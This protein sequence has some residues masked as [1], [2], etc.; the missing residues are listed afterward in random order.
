MLGRKPTIGLAMIVKDEAT[1]IGRCLRSVYGH[2]DEVL[3]VDTGSTDGTQAIAEAHGARVIPFAWV[4]DF[5]AARNFALENATTDWVLVLDADEE[6]E[7]APGTLQKV[8]EGLAI[9]QLTGFVPLVWVK[10]YNHAGSVVTRD[11]WEAMP[12]P[13]FFSREGVRYRGAAHE[14]PELPPG[15]PYK[16]LAYTAYNI[17][18]HHHGYRPEVMHGRDK[19]TRNIELMLKR[20]EAYP[21]DNAVNYLLGREQVFSGAYDA[22]IETLERYLSRLKPEERPSTFRLAYYLLAS[23]N[24]DL[25]RFE[26]GLQAIERGLAL[27]PE[28]PSYHFIKGEL[29][30]RLERY[31]E[32]IASFDKAIAGSNYHEAH[33]LTNFNATVPAHYGQSARDR[34]NRAEA[35]KAGTP[36]TEPDENAPPTAQTTIA[37][38]LSALSDGK[39]DDA[40]KYLGEAARLAPT[41]SQVPYLQAE[42]ALRRGDVGLALQQAFASLRLSSNMA[43]PWALAAYLL[44]LDEDSPLAANFLECALAI[45]PDYETARELLRV[46]KAN[47]RRLYHHPELGAWFQTKLAPGPDGKYRLS[48]R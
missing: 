36:P 20:I 15:S 23:A 19:V 4:Q 22:G 28:F 12:L 3:V 26:E 34:R 17:E 8:V 18:L 48:L 7:V 37:K 16:P 11:P 27:D 30:M 2:V 40:Q 24:G 9:P 6:L 41:H 39:L 43:E 45:S 5:A 44:H 21:D 25:E 35:L 13:R 42:L 47:P 46:V 33:P 14:Q 31:D 32:A 1:S 10:L 29:L 38:A